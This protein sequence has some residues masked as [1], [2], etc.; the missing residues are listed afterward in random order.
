MKKL[1]I[2]ALATGMALS[3]F[4]AS[5]LAQSMASGLYGE[6]SY[7]SLKTDVSST[8]NYTVKPGA[9]KIILGK[10]INSNL[11]IEGMLAV[12]VSDGKTNFTYAGQPV[13]LKAKLN[14]A[15]GFYLKPKMDLSK[16]VEVFAR[17]GATKFN[18]K[19]S[20]NV[21]SGYAS[22]NSSDSGF[23]YGG[24]LK[25]KLD[26]SSSLVVDYMQ[27]YKKDQTKINGLSVGVAYAF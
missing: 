4:T 5:A 21:G 25:Y 27:Y 17:V 20:V 15:Y 1:Q 14:D 7:V 16:E 19:E 13:E 11:A 24:G 23:S 18:Y 9:L 2:S 6:L 3:L 26:R 8:P 22:G 12:G 10:D